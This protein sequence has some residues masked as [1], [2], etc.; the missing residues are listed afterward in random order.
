M[1]TSRRN[2]KIAYTL[3][4]PEDVIVSIENQALLSFSA[5]KL[6]ISA[7]GMSEEYYIMTSRKLRDQYSIDEIRNLY[8]GFR[9][10]CAEYQ[11][12]PRGL[13]Q[14]LVGFS[15][16]T[17]CM[18]NQLP[19]VKRSELI[20]FRAIS[21]MLGQDIFTTSYLAYLTVTNRIP[22][23]TGFNWGTVLSTNDRRLD[24]L[25]KKGIAENHFHFAGSTPLFPLSW[26]AL[27][28][29]P[30]QI[31]TFFQKTG[32]TKNPF[33][34]NRSVTMSYSAGTRQLTWDESLR[35]AAWLRAK[36]FE[37][38]LGRMPNDQEQLLQLDFKLADISELSSTVQRLRLEFGV[39]FQQPGGNNRCVD[40]AIRGGNPHLDF[41]SP[42][43]F[44]YGERE[45]LYRC[46]MS[47]FDHSFNYYQQDLFFL[48]LL[49]KIRFRAEL[50]QVNREK[51]FA[52]F[53]IYQDRKSMFWSNYPEY[54]TEAHRLTVNADF[55]SG[56]LSTLEMRF[57]PDQ[58]KRQIFRYILE[59]DDMI[60]F[61]DRSRRFY[62]SKLS[63]TD[64]DE[65]KRVDVGLSLPFF[66]TL[67]FIKSQQDDPLF[68][69]EL[70]DQIQPRNYSIRDKARRCALSL[71]A[72]LRD[73]DYLCSRVRGIDAA[74]FEIHC[75]PETF[76]TEFR[77]LK[78]YM[79]NKQ[80]NG[81]FLT[82]KRV[83]PRIG[84]TYHVGE[85]FLDISDGLRAID[86]AVR[87]LDLSR[88][89]RLGHALA[90]GVSPELHYKAK[91]CLIS[92]PKQDML[93]NFVWLLL[94]SIELGI[95][96][97]PTLREKMRSLCLSLMQE[98]YGECCKRHHWNL[99]I[100]DYYRSWKLRG[101]H[102]DCYR[103]VQFKNEFDDPSR[104]ISQHSLMEKYRSMYLS[105]NFDDVTRRTEI[106]C[107][108]LHYYHYGRHERE[109][110]IE[111]ISFE[112]GYDYRVLMTE[113]QEKMQSMIALKGIAI[114]C[115]PSSNYLIGT[116]GKYENHPIFRFNTHLLSPKN[117]GNEICVSVNTDDQ[118]VFDTSLENEYA[119]LAECLA[120]MKDENNERIY[121]DETIYD[122]LD[123][124]RK[125][126]ISQT[127]P[128]SSK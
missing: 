6:C 109:K 20:N 94:R 32:R 71:A 16:K 81:F 116:F 53:S 27:M 122:Y 84:I 23:H 48:Y 110:G 52:N 55:D 126:G 72:S 113:M 4:S 77:F 87:F 70:L 90:L 57:Q 24:T 83:M 1:N 73:S 74:S 54:E 88:G 36:L 29:H 30:Q 8:H 108:I 104:L 19:I 11:S 38:S 37:M 121:S 106:I 82:S 127:F 111:C 22:R 60:L 62:P 115:N 35:Y 7:R 12:L 124:I 49:L 117:G 64:S 80:S 92:L 66:Y 102:P 85:D 79:P 128:A 91:G 97:N 100:D 3:V 69:D 17:L 44:L 123:Y 101:D 118:G 26:V 13:F 105:P 103:G 107:G 9:T 15:E 86:E 93:D 42:N 39:R 18:E 67:H 50:V 68:R 114:E 75:R 119:L 56:S 40:Y 33:T 98:I 95:E 78:T 43:R 61:A 65:A 31:R 28:N 10:A 99:T 58:Q 45:L 112:I 63:M 125:M 46:F 41:E 59:K 51:G 25:L 47:C 120:G 5:D 76:A 14:L 89:D 21:L 96:I 34:E 2:L